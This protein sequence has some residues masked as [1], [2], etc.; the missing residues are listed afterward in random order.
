MCADDVGATAT[1]AVDATAGGN[2]FGAAAFRS[3]TWP[4]RP[5][6]I[7]SASAA[8]KGTP[9]Q[10]KSLDFIFF[11]SRGRKCEPLIPT[12]PVTVCSYVRGARGVLARCET[13]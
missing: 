7:P 13:S 8:N 12:A 9:T 4:A 11:E 3:A 10:P 5:Q 1:V 6:P 2:G